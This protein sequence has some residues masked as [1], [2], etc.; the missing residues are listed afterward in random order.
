MAKNSVFKNM[1]FL[2][3]SG[4]AAKSFD[5]LFRAYYS[6]ML[7]SEGMGLLS[8]GFSFHSV[9]LTFATAGLGVAVSKITSEYMERKNAAAVKSSMHSAI[10]GVSVLSLIVILITFTFSGQFAQKFLGDSRVSASLCTLVPSVLF[11]GISYCLKGCFYAS[12]KIFPPASSE[13]LEQAVKFVCIK[14]LLKYLLPYGVEYGCAAVFAG[15]T[16]GELSSCAYL[17]YFYIKEEKRNYDL[18]L[19]E[20]QGIRTR[21]LVCAL[22]GVSIPSM[23]TSLCCS[24]LRMKEEV[25][26]VSSLERGGMSHLKALQSLG[27]IHGMA[28]PML[29]L[30]LS[31]MGS[32]MSLLVPEISRA[33]V[34]GR[35]RLKRVSVK[36][37]KIGSAIGCAVSIFFLLF[38]ENLTEIVY[39][40]R[41]AA[42]LVVTL[43][44]LCPIMFIDSLSC[45][46]LNGL[47]KQFRLLGFTIADFAIRLAIIYFALPKGQ[48]AAFSA[49]VAVSNIFTCALSFGSVAALICP[50][51]KL[52][53]PIKCDIVN[54]K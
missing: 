16:I 53:K 10:F 54:K 50:R 13:I 38:G 19:G 37:F 15:I 34:R 24:F 51:L 14:T 44:P 32:V 30:P 7:G 43:A 47:G 22:L 1:I 33:G 52:T 5:F 46:I 11:M 20:T 28:M 6:R 49:M 8:L 45:S 23:I 40:S 2:G 29:V 3:M 42:P 39:A 18:P 12:R 27:I 48:L 17:S 35:K 9:M 25:L 31:L 41:E 26:I 36:T 4:L 21:E